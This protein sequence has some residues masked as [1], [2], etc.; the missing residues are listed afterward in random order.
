V[1]TWGI[2]IG[3][4]GGRPE[5]Y[6]PTYVSQ[7]D[8]ILVKRIFSTSDAQATIAITSNDKVML[9]GINSSELMNDSY[10]AEP[11]VE[12]TELHLENVSEIANIS[13][14]NGCYY[15]IYASRKDMY[16][17]LATINKFFDVTIFAAI[18]SS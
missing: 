3:P 5:K 9:W 11:D 2:T 12:P 6:P 7:L 8:G 16:S 15:V 1:V 10:D 14:H 13:L 17:K 4:Y 18:N